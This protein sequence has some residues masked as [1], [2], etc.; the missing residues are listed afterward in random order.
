[1]PADIPQALKDWSATPGSNLP[2]GATLVST[3]LDD[4]LRNLQA[5]VR[6]EVASRGTIASGTTTD[7][8]T[9]D[10]GAIDVTGTTTITALGTVSA[11]MRKVLRFAGALTLTHN[12]T[13]LQLITAADITTAAGDQCEM[14]SLGS[15]NWRMVWYAK[16]SGEPVAVQTYRISDL[17]AAN[18]AKTL[19]NA[20]YEQQWGWTFDSADDYGLH[21]N[22]KSNGGGT[23]GHLLYLD[24]NT[25]GSPVQSLI[26]ASW[27]DAGGTT[28][29]MQLTNT[30]LT[31]R[32][33]NI[34]SGAAG[35]SYIAGTSSTVSSSGNGGSLTVSGGDGGAS[36]GT[37][38][39]L[40]LTS[41][42]GATRGAV[43]LYSSLSAAALIATD[44]AMTIS[45]NTK[46][47]LDTRHVFLDNS[48]GTPTITAGGGTGAT[49]R[50]S[51]VGFEVTF[52]TGS[53]TSVTVTFANAWASVPIVL[54]TG[55]Q[56]GQVIHAS[57]GTTTVQILSST[58]FSSGTKVAVLCMGLQ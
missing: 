39:G 49:I 46:T 30:N 44:S 37:G 19:A 57:P 10:A 8:S 16:A 25:N 36:S 3:N 18:A 15:G 29:L 52:G 21:L 22:G 41:G 27:T 47:V 38:G 4:N 9:V 35:P 6:T 11:G 1:M 42:G 20:A 26:K 58:A 34:L 48:N 31:L 56:S 51:D 33:G 50:G 53:P 12:A 2:S 54:A 43:N 28:T 13:S 40:V 45:G 5:A 7:L 17:S 23:Y 14:E 55:T 24:A 32:G